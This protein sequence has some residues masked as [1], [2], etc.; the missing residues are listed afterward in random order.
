MRDARRLGVELLLQRHVAARNATAAH[1]GGRSPGCHMGH[2]PPSAGAKAYSARMR[3]RALRASSSAAAA[4]VRCSSV[5]AT[6]NWWSTP[7]NFMA[8]S[9]SA[10]DASLL[11]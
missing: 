3:Y 9:A 11:P 2:G 5:A 1:D 8:L 10:S 4:L 6:P 7:M